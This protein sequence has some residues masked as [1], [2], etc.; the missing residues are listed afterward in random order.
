MS[1]YGG[2]NQTHKTTIAVAEGVKQSAIM[3]AT[4]QSAANAAE[5]VF[6][7]ACLASAL[8]NNVSPSTYLYGLRQLTG[9]N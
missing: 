4:T 1:Q 5:T 7:R 3:A 6:L 2:D 9:G 8:A